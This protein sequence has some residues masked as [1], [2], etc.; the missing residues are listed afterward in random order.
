MSAIRIAMALAVAG[1]ALVACGEAP[2]PTATPLPTP[3]AGLPSQN[4]VPTATA[5]PT[6][7]PTP[8]PTPTPIPTSDTHR[9]AVSF[10][11]DTPI[12]DAELL[13]LLVKH[14]AKGR[15]AHTEVLEYRGSSQAAEPTDPHTF[16]STI[17]EEMVNSFSPVLKDDGV[18]SEAR[19]LANEYTLND[20]RTSTSARADAA[21]FVRWSNAIA[22]ARL[23]E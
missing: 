21:D 13:A 18:T 14:N 17:R 22:Q 15:W 7:T 1:V 5:T 9:A 6:P 4:T 16:V 12:G 19:R 20:L 2:T 10:G 8:S 3:A 23:C 11:E